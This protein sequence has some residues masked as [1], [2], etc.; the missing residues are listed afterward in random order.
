MSLSKEQQQ[1]FEAF[2]K[3]LGFKS[4]T[5]SSFPLGKKA[6]EGRVRLSKDPAKSSGPPKMITVNTIDEPKA[7]INAPDTGS[8][9]RSTI[10]V[11]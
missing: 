10:S 1:N 7:L 11:N 4:G 5:L 8:D 2:N 3:R 9:D 6:T